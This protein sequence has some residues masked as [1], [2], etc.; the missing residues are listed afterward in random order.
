MQYAR[1]DLAGGAQQAWTGIDDPGLGRVA[2]DR[3][4]VPMVAGV[5]ISI[6]AETVIEQVSLARAGQVDRAIAGQGFVEQPD[7]CS[8][9]ADQS[10]IGATAQ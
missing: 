1:T 9:R 6:R 8:H 5:V 2:P 10:L 3:Q 7:M 4:I